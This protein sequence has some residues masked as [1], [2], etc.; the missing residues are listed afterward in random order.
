MSRSRTEDGGSA[1]VTTLLGRARLRGRT[2]AAWFYVIV[3]LGLVGVISRAIDRAPGPLWVLAAPLPGYALLAYLICCYTGLVRT[4]GD[5]LA[6]IPPLPADLPS[7]SGR[8]VRRP[9]R[10]DRGSAKIPPV[11]QRAALDPSG[12]SPSATRPRNA[13][14]KAS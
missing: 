2:P 5:A 4:H 14:R 6:G 11:G 9:F 12:P 3:A 1:D 13:C 10:R 8:G 7:A